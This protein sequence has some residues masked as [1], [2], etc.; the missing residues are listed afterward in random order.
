MTELSTDY[1]DMHA[2][3]WTHCAK[4]AEDDAFG[5]LTSFALSQTI[6]INF[7][8]KWFHLPGPSCLESHHPPGSQCFKNAAHINYSHFASS[9]KI[10]GQ[11]ATMGI[12][13]FVFLVVG[14]A[15]RAVHRK[16]RCRGFT[17][18]IW[19]ILVDVL[20]M[21]MSWCLF[22]CCAT[23]WE[24]VPW[25][26]ELPV[27]ALWANAG[28]VA[29]ASMGVIIFLDFLADRAR[30]YANVVAGDDDSSQNQENL[31]LLQEAADAFVQELRDIIRSLGL[32]VGLC[33]HA[34]WDDSNYMILDSTVFAE[35]PVAAQ[36]SLSTVLVMFVGYGWY[37][38]IAPLARMQPTDHK[39]VIESEEKAR[40]KIEDAIAVRNE[41]CLESECSDN[42]ENDDTN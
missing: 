16:L 17:K 12:A 30:G 15:F 4:A 14:L 41:A 6:L 33:F 25:W 3:D 36:C 18:R 24:L 28:A 27:V 35:H 19:T 10:A 2:H 8:G 7:A 39:L 26:G 37:K 42:Y 23:A 21:S 11:A 1:T 34:A 13:A 32:L 20:L 29:F 38:F 9:E 31:E 5:L 22:H 40:R